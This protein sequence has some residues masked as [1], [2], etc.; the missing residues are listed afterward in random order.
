[1]PGTI[2]PYSEFCPE[3]CQI[4]PMIQREKTGRRGKVDVGYV[5]ILNQPA[6]NF[7]LAKKKSNTDFWI[8]APQ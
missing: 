2:F 5:A 3:K 8:R 1:M 6:M 7:C 4:I